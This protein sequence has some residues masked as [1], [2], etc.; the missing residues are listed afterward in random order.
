MF[1]RG[2]PLAYLGVLRHASV[3]VSMLK[4]RSGLCLAMHTCPRAKRS[5]DHRDLMLTLHSENID[6]FRISLLFTVLVLSNYL[7]R[8][9]L[10]YKYNRKGWLQCQE[11]NAKS[12]YLS[13]TKYIHGFS[14]LLHKFFSMITQDII[15]ICQQH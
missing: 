1:I 15:S 9:F 11:L 2:I 7:H 13:F 12:L 10:I 8:W 5:G 4:Q 6:Q 3:P 14:K